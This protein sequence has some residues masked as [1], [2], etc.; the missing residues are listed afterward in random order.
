VVLVDPDAHHKRSLLSSFKILF[1]A[2]KK[3]TVMPMGIELI[4]C[5][6]KILEVQTEPKWK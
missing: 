2:A 5:Q 3:Y 4:Y 1:E 6:F